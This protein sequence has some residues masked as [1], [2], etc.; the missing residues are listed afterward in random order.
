MQRIDKMLPGRQPQARHGARR[1]PRRQRARDPG[2]A[3]RPARRTRSLADLVQPAASARRVSSVEA[4][5]GR[6]HRASALHCCRSTSTRSTRSSALGALDPAR[7]QQPRPLSRGRRAADH[8]PGVGDARRRRH[9]RRDRLRHEPVPDAGPS[10]LLGRALPRQRRERRQAPLH[11]PAQGR[12]LAQDAAGPG[13][14]E[15]R[16]RQEPLPA[17]P[18]RR[19]CAP[20]AARRRRSSPSPPRS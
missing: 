19:V 4:L 16:A 5:R 2:G 7:R 1:H 17:R 13:R 11:A 20:G 14:V 12:A 10:D 9:R 18:V 3:G 15:R 6:R 8:H